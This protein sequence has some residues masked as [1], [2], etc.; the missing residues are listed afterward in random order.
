MGIQQ[1]AGDKKAARRPQPAR[2]VP[3]QEQKL[4][5][6]ASPPPLAA[7]QQQIGNQAVA[8]LLAQR[9]GEAPAELDDG[10]AAR[11]N[12]ARG[13]G[14]PLDGAI[15]S[16]L[17]AAFGHDLSGVRVHTSPE[18]DSLSRALNARAFTT[19]RDIFFRS[20]AYEPHSTS[21]RQLIAH[22]VTHVVQQGMGAVPSAERMTVNPPGDVFEQEADAVARALAGGPTSIQ[23]QSQEE[24]EE[25]RVQLQAEQEEEEPIQAQFEEEEEEG[26]QT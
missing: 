22:E 13:E 19:G 15:G 18:A 12:R 8:R 3:G 26:A 4:A 1:L 5:Q 9:S 25:E 6:A 20:G 24:E 10:T 14:Q 7:L 23:R 2:P 11:I 16:E 17:G 21:G